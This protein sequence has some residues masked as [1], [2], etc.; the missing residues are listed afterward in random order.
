MDA[1]IAIV[2][3]VSDEPK[4]CMLASRAGV[5]AEIPRELLMLVDDDLAAF[6]DD[7]RR[8]QAIYIFQRIARK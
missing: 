3:R 5:Q 6:N 4:E 2:R 1:N 7:L 8:Q